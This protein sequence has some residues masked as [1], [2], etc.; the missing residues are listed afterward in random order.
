MGRRTV[1][2]K[3]L[4]WK[5]EKISKDEW[6]KR[7]II[8]LRRIGWDLRRI[9]NDKEMGLG[10]SSSGWD[11]NRWRYFNRIFKDD[12]LVKRE[13]GSITERIEKAYFPNKS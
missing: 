10:F 13:T 7:T 6:Q 2:Q 3:L 9:W 5:I 8:K 12:L 11:K 1:L 4:D